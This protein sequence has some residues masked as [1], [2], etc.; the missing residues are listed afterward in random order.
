MQEIK[1][2]KQVKFSALGADEEHA[3]RKLQKKVPANELEKAVE[4]ECKRIQRI[5]AKASYFL[6][7]QLYDFLKT[8]PSIP[9]ILGKFYDI[10]DSRHGF[11]SRTN[12]HYAA[13]S[14]DWVL[15]DNEEMN[16]VDS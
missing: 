2:A 14:L 6:F 9:N 4:Q 7:R 5:R 16:D 15:K 8:E 12:A 13:E 11:G 1:N 3:V 10:L